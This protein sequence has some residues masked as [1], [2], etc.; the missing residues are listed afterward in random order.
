MEML[1]DEHDRIVRLGRE[2]AD[3]TTDPA[4]R[5]DLVEVLS[6]TVTRHLSA[7]EQYLYPTVRVAL[8]DGGTLADREIAADVELLR[9]LRDLAAT[10]PDDPDFDGLAATVSEQLRRHVHAAATELFPPLRQIASDAEL[11]RLGNRVEI[12]VEAAPTRPRPA[13]PTTPP[14]NKVVEPALGMV[15]K[16]RDAVTRR[17]TYIED[18]STRPRSM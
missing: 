14:W 8:P 5:R 16:V 2:L 15:D 6:A 10:T 7:E 11:I 3:P 18:L 4:H 13:T 12:A 9:T 17:R 1:A